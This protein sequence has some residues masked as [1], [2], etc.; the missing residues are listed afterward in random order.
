MKS[1]S[2]LI[3]AFLTAIAAVALLPVSGTAAS[4]AITAT[5]ILT[6]LFGDY[7]RN[8]DPVRA[9]APVVPF[10]SPGHAILAKAA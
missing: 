4:L 1:N 3:S 9:S 6:I 8:L 10:G 7:S 2:L 5:G